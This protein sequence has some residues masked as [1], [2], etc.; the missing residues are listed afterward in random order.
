L[1]HKRA[2]SNQQSAIS[3][4]W[5]WLIAGCWL[6][7]A[8]AGCEALQR[9]FTRKPKHPAPRPNPIIQFHDYTQ[10]MTPLDRYQKHYMLFDYWNSQ[11]LAA[12]ESSP[13]NPKRY[14]RAS[15]EALGELEQ[16]KGLATEEAAA[17]F[18]PLLEERAK[19]DHELQRGT[20]SDIQARTILSA[21]ERQTRQIHRELFWRDMQDHLKEPERAT[22]ASPSE[23]AEQ[24]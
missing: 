4:G 13:L 3:V 18:D 14:T 17:R 12:L 22:E 7:M 16:L 11:L 5:V 8:A 19:L 10:A 1:E 2:I 15:T 24:P 6:L 21:L 23:P 20:F 9:K